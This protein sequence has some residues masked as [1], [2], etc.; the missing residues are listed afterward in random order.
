MS[1][2]NQTVGLYEC[3]TCG[4]LHIGVQTVTCCD[5]AMKSI[6]V[7]DQMVEQPDAEQLLRDI[8][9][10]S[11]TRIEI[12]LF[13]MEADDV[14]AREVAKTVG[15]DRSTAQRHLTFL[16]ELGVIEKQTRNLQTG[17]SMFI[18]MP[19]DREVIHRRLKRH[20]CVWMR[21]AFRVTDELH[22]QKLEQ[23]A[24]RSDMGTTDDSGIYYD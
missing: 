14:T 5:G 1:T 17:G 7:G 2:H 4:N 22:Q 8:F 6:D 3:Q 12:C 24:D 15:I 13:V 19:V 10:F 20:L 16:V 23:I 21:E 9:G 18:Y 11:D